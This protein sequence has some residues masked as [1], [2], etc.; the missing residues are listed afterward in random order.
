MEVIGH[1]LDALTSVWFSLG[2]LKQH[3]YYPG[4]MGLSSIELV[5]GLMPK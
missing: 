3:V 5:H 1:I 2:E 4:I